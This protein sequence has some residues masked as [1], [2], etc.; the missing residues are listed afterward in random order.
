MPLFLSEEEFRLLSHDAAAVAERADAVIR[1][2]RYQVDTAKAEKDA[3]AIAAEQTCAL[4]E[5]RYESLSDDLARLRSENAQLSV[6]VEQRLSEIAEIQAEKHQLHLK[7]IGKD[8]EIER[9]SLETVELHKSKRQ[10]LEL[11]EQK[12]VE[13]REKNATIQSYLDKIVS[14]TDNAAAKE[15]RL[16]DSEAELA[17]CR[18]TC[19]RLTQ[20]KELLERHNVW[21][22]EELSAKVNSLVELR[23]THMDVEADLSAKLADF[24]RQMNES[25]SLLKRSKE[26]V[27]ELEMRITSL[28][29]E[30]CSSKGA[31]AANEEHF[32]A[33]LSTVTKL[34]ELYKAS[35]EEWS[36]KAGELEGVIK[37]LETHMTQVENEYKEKF[38]KELSLRKDLEKEAAVMKE[39]LEKCEAEIE[40]ARK[41]NESS[42]LPLS[43]FRA[44]PTLEELDNTH[45]D[46]RLVVPKTPLGISGTALAAS[47]L[48]DGWSLAKMYEK[49]QE[50]ADALRHEKWGR[51]HAEAILERVLHEIEEKA[52]IILDERAEHERMVEAYSLMNQKLQQALLEHDNFE[53][54]IRNLKSE[55]KKR[56]RDQTIAQKEISDLEKQVTV[57]LKECQ[58]IQLR[59]GATPQFPG[60]KSVTM[61]SVD[62][63]DGTDARNKISEPHMMFKDIH[64]LVEQNVQLRGLVHSLT[65]EDEK[66]DFELRESFQIELQKV[67]D[68]ATAKVEAVLKRSEEQGHMIESLHS[69]VAMYKRLYEEER[70]LRASSHVYTESVPGDGKKELMLL[71]EGSQ[72]V[73]KKAYEQLTERA[74]NLEED[75]AKLRGELTSI[76]SERDK[77]IL[78]ASF[79]RER[80]DSFKKE[81]EHQRKEANAVSARNV[82]LTHL[83][84]DYQ[85]RLRESSDSLQASEE[86]LRK[87]SMEVS[88]LKH[89][90]EILINSEKRASDE[91]RSLSERVHRL[92]SS[93]DTIQNTEEVRETARAAERR[94]HDKYLKQ[95]E[96]DWAETKKELQEER[97]HVRALMLDREKAMDNSMRQVDEMRKELADAWRAVA[98]AESRAAVAEARCSDLEA[99]LGCTEKKVIKKS[100]GNDPSAFSTDEVTGESWKVKEEMEKLKE[101]AQANKDFML[102][103]KEI[104]Y[105]NEVALKQ[106]E[107]AHEEYKA[108]AEKLRK[109]LE[110]EV[111]SLRNKVSELEKNY[112]LKC[113]EAASAVESKERELSFVLAETSG[114]RDEIAQKMTQIEGLE[115]QISSLKDDLDREHMRWRTAQD[116]F[117]R[118]V[119]L[120]AEA[121]QE[122]TNTS[123]ELSLLQSEIA[124]LRKISDAQK[125]ENDSLKA[126]WEKEKSELQAQKDGAERKYNEINEQ[127]KIL[128]NRLDS[129]HIRLA[130]REQSYAGFSSQNVDS[131]AESDL[132]NVI[133]YLRRSKEIAETEISLLKQEKL[134]LQSQLESSI[135]AS[136][137]AQTLLHSQ[138]EN[139]KAILFKDDEFKSLQLQVREIN[140]LRESN[141]QLREENK[142]NFEEC[143]KLR[144]EVQKA[145]MGAERFENLLKEKQIEFDAC[146]KEVEMHRMEIGHLNNRIVELVESCKNIDPA[147]H[148]RMKDELQ[149]IKVLLKENEMEVQLTKNLL[150]EKQE[151]I[152]NL[153]QALVKCQSELAEQVKR[154]N[155]ALQIEAN[156][157]QENDKQKK[158]LSILK[159]KN[160]TL[161]KEKEEL[162]KENQAL[163]K[164]IEDLK[165]ST[166][167]LSKQIEGL[168]S[169]TND[170]SASVYC[171]MYCFLF[172]IWSNLAAKK[173]TA[174]S[175]DQAA[176]E[177]DTRIQILEKTLERERDDNKKEK[178]K[179]QKNEKAVLD[180]MQTVN[181]D[182]RRLVE[183]LSKHKLAI[184]A[185]V[186]GTGL[187]DTQLP[188]GFSLDEE[189]HKYFF[190]TSNL[191]EA[192]NSLLND[193]QGS[194]PLTSDTS[195]VDTSMAAPGR[196]VPSQQARLST[197]PHV[198]TTQEKEKGSA[199]VKPVSEA[200]KGGRRL[201]RPRL[202][203]PEEPQVDIEMSGMEGSTA[204]EEGKV[205]TSHEP[206]LLGDISSRHPSSAR[207]RLAS[208]SAPELREESVSQ[209]ET[210]PDVAP[211]LKKSKDS[212]VQEAYEGKTIAS[213]SENPDT[214]PQSS[215]PSVDISDTQPPVED[216]ESDQAPALSGED[217]VDTAKDDAATNEE[218]EEHQKLSMDGANQEDDIQYEG[219]AIAE[220]VADKSRAPLDLLD[221]CLKNEDGREILQSL[222]ADGEEEREEGELLPDEPEQ[223]QEDGTSVECQHESA[224]GDGDRTGDETGELVEAASPEV[225]SESVDAME[226]VAEGND[227]SD[228]GAPDT[229]QSPQTSAGISEVPPSTPPQSAV[230]EQQSASTVAD[231]EESRGHRTITI[232][233]RARQNAILRQQA[234]M[235]A[236][237]P[238]RRGRAAG[239]YRRDGNRGGSRGGRGGRGSAFGDREQV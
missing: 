114:L 215:V 100:G 14:L 183:E 1:D 51:K 69:S 97:D 192:V 18:A 197:T 7:A 117:E 91:V 175:V 156:I 54:T 186:E 125:A 218:I 24:E 13:I 58:D 153:E 82:E 141:M 122:L 166:N 52:E 148:E 35:S 139:S 129:L 168:K 228:H 189:T 120:Q 64:G 124:K 204:A 233:E 23:K 177:K 20:E 36:K 80:L 44:D 211:P 85:K 188:P 113:E 59:C 86:N 16:N 31:A 232:S 209:E 83:L 116:N 15:A 165:S 81:F 21:L 111:L 157:R 118:Q 108:E 212:D 29:E 41:A 103:Y 176:K 202:E 4:L 216:T 107:S 96:R 138:H 136:E 84:V 160:E 2:L 213:S 159:K 174:D 60:E 72:E 45:E 203:R 76:R 49:Y 152:S 225:V 237:P 210:G 34:A 184:R 133:S 110:D 79:A 201:V 227:N 185:V 26:R 207:K 173:N 121:I 236:Q 87:L 234:R 131:K 28:E 143:Q 149:Q 55:L 6:S 3:A 50:A 126:L 161:T 219:D 181:K 222:A 30:L 230:S 179:R 239:S 98:S 178:A 140:L 191:G 155:D 194:H 127:N 88:I 43:S 137:R 115:F 220:E 38:E 46:G 199:V 154:L 27:T 89:E 47:L 231:T 119:V 22:N 73:S 223:Q 62:I 208:S 5:Q 95:V 56:E 99:K 132:Q 39:K 196:Q 40:I 134:R 25:S 19:N 169:S 226:E 224:P 53:N 101:E 106:I 74:R 200:R 150:S 105:T 123:K 170:H 163:S 146:Q 77:M 112:V 102:Q 198:K 8:G 229:V 135:K 65:S 93:L 71:F 12:D 145:K 221:E 37:A 48:R 32:A 205:G 182:K 66:R 142:H 104:A 11:V 195:T 214:A 158:I 33:E 130:E 162:N 238:S 151:T 128:H 68:E 75:L 193:G 90:K 61:I 167:A 57:L 144:D 164:Q 10:L 9:L 94:K 147:E 109:S 171:Y 187:T 180:I 217:I 190:S 206:E 78:E 63:D 70:R 17:H 42:I 172:L 92:Q 235:T 67:T